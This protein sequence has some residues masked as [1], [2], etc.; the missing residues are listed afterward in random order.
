MG[1]FSS[2]TSEKVVSLPTVTQLVGY[3]SE[4]LLHDPKHS[5]SLKTGKGRLYG[6]DICP[7]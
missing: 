4:S 2:G 3:H 1:A 6:L 7:L 5:D